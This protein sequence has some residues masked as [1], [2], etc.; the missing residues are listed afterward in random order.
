MQQFDRI[1]ISD[2]GMIKLI[3]NGG[4]DF[5]FPAARINTYDI[6]EYE[7]QLTGDFAGIAEL[8]G[9][10]LGT[11][12]KEKYHN[13]TLYTSDDELVITKIEPRIVIRLDEAINKSR[14]IEVK[15]YGVFR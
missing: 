12:K 7:E 4:K 8:I 10:L 9:T 6:K 2:K 1:E 5:I 15:K 11:L 3:R 13:L 14:E